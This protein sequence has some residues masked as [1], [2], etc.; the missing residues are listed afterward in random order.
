MIKKMIAFKN[1]RSPELNVNVWYLRCKLH[2]R[3]DHVHCFTAV[4]QRQEDV[5]EQNER[6]R[7]QT[8]QILSIGH[9]QCLSQVTPVKQKRKY[10]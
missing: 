5:A 4:T 3:S 1:G 7:C 2:G 10:K 6:A 9:F 8:V